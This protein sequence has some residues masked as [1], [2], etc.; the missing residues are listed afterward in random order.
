MPAAV[1]H[2]D[3]LVA[4]AAAGWAHRERPP[5]R[6]APYKSA[7]APA[8][9]AGERPH[10]AP[11][12]QLEPAPAQH[13][14]RNTACLP[15]RW[16]P[17][18][19]APCRTSGSTRQ[20]L[21]P[22]SLILRSALRFA[23]RPAFLRPLFQLSL[24][25]INDLQVFVPFHGPIPRPLHAALG[26]APE[27]P[28]H[29]QR[30]HRHC[31]AH[32]EP[33]P[34]NESPALAQ[35]P[36]DPGKLADAAVGP[37]VDFSQNPIHQ[38]RGQ[39]H[40]GCPSDELYRA[41]GIQRQFR[42]GRASIAM[43]LDNGPLSHRQGPIQVIRQQH[44]EFG[45]SN[46]VHTV[47]RLSPPVCLRRIRARSA[48]PRFNLDFTVPSGICSTSAISRYSSSSRSRR[49]TVSRN[50]GDSLCSADC[51]ISLASRPASMPSARAATAVVFSITGSRSSIDS[52]ARSSLVLR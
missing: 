34:Q 13:A 45:A 31:Q 11:K 23:G 16:R 43:L 2:F 19:P 41:R 36:L 5:E 37:A 42:A 38:G 22:S 12:P 25:V 44:F 15:R 9:E 6:E 3:R 48:R 8:A 40:A 46:P 50:S 47:A 17:F 21:L 29:R 26:R 20:S 27:S 4:E 49:I 1:K 7:E 32:C 30:N 18:P 39:V 24:H 35:Q 10:P 51:N 52:V 14:R 28:H 33:W